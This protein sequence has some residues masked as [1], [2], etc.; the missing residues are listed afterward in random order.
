MRMRL[1]I[2]LLLVGSL[3]LSIGACRRSPPTTTVA[4]G[5]DWT[6]YGRTKDEQRFSPLSQI[7]EQNIGRLGLCGIKNSAPPG[8]SKR[9]HSSP[10]G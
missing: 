4:A 1:S 9:L 10:T 8:A 6:M 2:S 3:V 7:N 5:A